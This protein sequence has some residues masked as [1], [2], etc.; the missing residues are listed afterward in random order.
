MSSVPRSVV[1]HP[2]STAAVTMAV[3]AAIGAA[4][5]VSGSSA[6]A[7]AVGLLAAVVLVTFVAKRVAVLPGYLGIEVP[8]LLILVST[9]VWRLRDTTSLASQPLD[10]AGLLRLV[11]IGLGG[12][13]GILAIL[14][15]DVRGLIGRLRGS[16]PLWIYIAYLGV[17]ILGVIPSSFPFLTLFR[18]ANLAVVLVV[19]L[20]AYQTAGDEAI[21]RLE[22]VLLWFMIFH[23][24]TVWFWVFVS[25]HQAL[26]HTTSPFPYRIEGLFPAMSTDR[27][28]EYGVILFFWGLAS[29]IGIGNDRVIKSR[30][31]SL[32]L[33]GFGAICLLFAQYRT[34][35][36]AMAA[37]V[38]VLLV[39]RRK[40]LWVAAV[41]VGGVLAAVL[42]GI[43]SFLLR[44]QNYQLAT[45]LSGRDTLWS[46]A[47]PVWKH[48]PIIGN[49]LETA[50]RFDVLQGLG[51]GF[52]STLHSTWIEA[53][54][55]TGVVGAALVAACVLIVGWRAFTTTMHRGRILP[56]LVV[57]VLLVRSVTGTSF[58]AF[59]LESMLFLVFAM[60]LRKRQPQEPADYGA[61]LTAG[62]GR[63]GLDWT[64]PVALAVGASGPAPR[65]A[66]IGSDRG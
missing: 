32:A 56:L 46:A 38:V 63:V 43:S 24:A 17:V 35:Y 20:G 62:D 53:L 47:I 54:V 13:L 16:R 28:G 27:I 30:R 65:E 45:K 52:T 39:V 4:I 10:A 40:W 41:F 11:T 15:G 14:R 33:A 48:S 1:L 50:S 23:L 29:W 44:G 6:V 21:H 61:L 57:G 34:G 42:P 7:A 22:K 8:A 5:G 60:A 3:G 31:W 58:E 26:R 66:L 59:S 55:G 2:L 64:H 19:L 49:G 36:V 37:G 18:A 51:R 25:P 12:L 9:L